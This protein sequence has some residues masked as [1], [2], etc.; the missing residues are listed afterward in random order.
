MVAPLLLVLARPIT[1]AFRALP[2]GRSR[3]ALVTVVRSVPASVLV[4][5]PVAAVLDVG[6]LWALY[7]TGLFSFTEDHPWAHAF[8]HL[9]VFAAGLLFSAAICRLEPFRHRCPPTVRAATLVLA[10]AAHSVLAKSLWAT[11][12]YGTAFSPA[13]V[14]TGAE[15]MYYGGDLVEIGLAVAVAVQWYAAGGSA[16]R[17]VSPAR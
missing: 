16:R 1:L 6:G 11:P 14:H 15:I 17:A 10:G 5:P 13:D 12:P 4:F 8:V 7:R 2:P 9:H 3:R